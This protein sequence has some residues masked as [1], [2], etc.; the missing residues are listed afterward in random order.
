MEF[1]SYANTLLFKGGPII[2]PL[3]LLSIVGWAAAIERLLKIFRLPKREEARRF[4]DRIFALVD[5][6]EFLRA[7]TECVKFDH[8]VG[9]VFKAALGARDYDREDVKAVM[10]R[11]ANAEVRQLERNF[12]FLISIT[13]VAPMLGFLGTIIGLI[14]AF[15]SW[16]RLAENVTVSALAAGIYEAM[17]STAAGLCVAIPLYLIYQALV[18]R[19]RYITS[20]L[21][22]LGD[23]MIL[24]LAHASPRKAAR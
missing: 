7:E 23:E 8:P 12:G 18:S 2:I 13:G 21:S 4:A 15:R 14:N 10:E 17:I 16:E 20:D 19:V 1:F 24:R 11:V 22:D 5:S 3:I 6:E 9:R